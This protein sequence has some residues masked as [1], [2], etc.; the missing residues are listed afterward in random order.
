MAKFTE[1]SATLLFRQMR[2]QLESEYSPNESRQF[3]MILLDHFAG[4]DIREMII[5]PGRIVERSTQEKINQSVLRLLK[6]E[7]IQYITGIAHFCGYEFRVNPDVLIPRPETEELVRLVLED[8]ADQH[9][10]KIADLGTGSGCIAISLWLRFQ[11]ASVDAFDI[12]AEALTIA[13]K[14]NI[15]FGARVSFFQTDL[16]DPNLWPNEN[17]DVIVSNP[18]Y[19]PIK[20]KELLPINVAW[21]EPATALFVPDNDPLLFYR[22]IADF[23]NSRLKKN[24][25]VYM[26]VHED[27]A[28]KV[29]ELFV[30]SSFDPVVLRKDINGKNRMVKA[31]KSADHTDY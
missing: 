13:R 15:E 1:I 24:G 8:Y 28:D 11:D 19:I 23:A 10:L 3:A 25:Q 6:H 29:V 21:F 12:S 17:Y 22:I 5:N 26:E 20:N 31:R 14:N 27:F 2:S 9:N 7:P 30:K 16:C 18:P 4:I